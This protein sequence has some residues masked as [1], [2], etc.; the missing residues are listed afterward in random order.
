MVASFAIIH[1]PS[2]YT[3]QPSAYYQADVEAAG[4]WLR[5]N[6]KLGVVRGSPVRALDFDLL[7]EGCDTSGR[8]LV[9]TPAF[10]RRALGVDITLSSPKAVS[11]LYAVGDEEL[12]KTIS[13]AEDAAVEATIRLIE[14][15]IPPR[16]KG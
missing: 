3:S 4:I 11:V 1:R 14:T 8:K 12:R 2:Y 7:C 5:G 9:K 10:K 15:E 16:P 13:E 6:E